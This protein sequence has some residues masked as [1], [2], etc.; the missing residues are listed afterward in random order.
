MVYEG[1][2]TLAQIMHNNS[3]LSTSACGDLYQ[4]MAPNHGALACIPCKMKVFTSRA[5]AKSRGLQSKIYIATPVNVHY[6]ISIEA[7]L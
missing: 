2:F 4:A 3:L 1:K 6:G 7:V 5:S